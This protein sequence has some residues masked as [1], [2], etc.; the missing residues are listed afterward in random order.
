MDSGTIFV[1]VQVPCLWVNFPKTDRRARAES[2]R[3]PAVVD[4]ITVLQS[5]FPFPA[6]DVGLGY[7]M[8]M[9]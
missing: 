9:L 6:T 4:F 5:S 7:D 2:D 1:E 3:I 8:G